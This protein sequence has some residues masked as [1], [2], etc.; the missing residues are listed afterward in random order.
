MD[1]LLI[2]PLVGETRG[3][4]LIGAVELVSNKETKEPFAACLIAGVSCANFAANHGLIVRAIGDNIAFTQPLIITNNQVN[5]LFDKMQVALD[6][7]L[8]MLK[9]AEAA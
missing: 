1:G 2:H 9:K 5:E 4:G 3:R 8:A 7:T 6:D